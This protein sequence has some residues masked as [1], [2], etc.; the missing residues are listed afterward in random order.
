MMDWLYNSYTW[1]VAAIK[2]YDSLIT[3]L[4]AIIIVGGAIYIFID[5]LWNKFKGGYKDV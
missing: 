5:W 4:L 3:Y 1:L 2:I